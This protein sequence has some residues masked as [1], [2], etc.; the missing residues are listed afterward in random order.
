MPIKNF[1]MLTKDELRNLSTEELVMIMS[2]IDNTLVKKCN[3]IKNAIDELVN[4]KSGRGLFT[5]EGMPD[6]RRL[7]DAIFYKN[8]PM[9][10]RGY[11]FLIDH[12]VIEKYDITLMELYNYVQHLNKLGKINDNEK[13]LALKAIPEKDLVASPH[14]YGIPTPEDQ[15]DIDVNYEDDYDPEIQQKMEEY[16]EMIYDKTVKT[17][18]N[19]GNYVDGVKTVIDTDMMGNLGYTFSSLQKL[20]NTLYEK[21]IIERKVY[22]DVS[23]VITNRMS[24]W[25]RTFKYIFPRNFETNKLGFSKDNM[26][27]ESYDYFELERFVLRMYSLGLITKN[28]YDSAMEWIDRYIKIDNIHKSIS[29]NNNYW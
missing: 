3:I 6:N 9:Y 26:K 7:F 25:L 18:D 4:N 23:W 10:E 28:D 15:M 27:K 5:R 20:V 22:E 11:V 16:D 14:N 12:A 29:S 2:Y 17:K 1:Y 21:D 8:Y 19:D 13:Q 24:K